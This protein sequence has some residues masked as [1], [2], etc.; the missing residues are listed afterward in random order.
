MDR[1]RDRHISSC[2]SHALERYR[3][4]HPQAAAHDAL[5]CA[6]LS[7]RIESPLAHAL[8][9]RPYRTANPQSDSAEHRLHPEC[10][11]IFVL[12]AVPTDDTQLYIQTYL[13]LDTAQQREAARRWFAEPMAVL[14][15]AFELGFASGAAAEPGAV[16][17]IASERAMDDLLAL[18]PRASVAIRAQ[19][20][21]PAPAAPVGSPEAALTCAAIPVA[22]ALREAEGCRLPAQKHKGG[23]EPAL[24]RWPEIPAGLIRASQPLSG[25][26][27]SAR[28]AAARIEPHGQAVAFLSRAPGG[29]TVVARVVPPPHADRQ[30]MLSAA[31]ATPL[32][33][34][35]EGELSE[36]GSVSGAEGAPAGVPP[37]IE[38][39]VEACAAQVTYWSHRAHA[40]L[41][42]T[43]ADFIPAPYLN[44]LEAVPA[45]ELPAL[46][47]RLQWRFA[48]GT[49]Y[50]ARRYKTVLYLLARMPE[51]TTFMVAHVG[52]V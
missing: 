37:T 26:A 21:P 6:R 35:P 52:R 27:R 14:R 43:N 48:V 19:E 31:S 11:G 49:S 34:L 7:L 46:A 42:K 51:A 23:W 32:L 10:T 33:P 39:C 28:A 40:D 25:I 5:A 13:R 15:S 20:A 24:E 47:T 18:L 1:M 44:D 2:S 22:A 12:R 38:A 3:R 36:D 29:G 17:A 4:H 50:A 9:G 30:A 41:A 8:V 16:A 45:A